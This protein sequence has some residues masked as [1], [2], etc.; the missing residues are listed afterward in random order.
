MG[1][2]IIVVIFLVL[3]LGLG[4][5]LF[6]SGIL[7]NAT[8]EFS[9]LL[10]ASSSTFFNAGS[11]YVPPV[12]ISQGSPTPSATTTIN[13]ADVPAGFTVSQLSPYFHKV[14]FGGVEPGSSGEIIL[15]G[16]MSPSSSIDITGWEIKSNR[17][18]EYVPQAIDLYDPSGLARAGDI[19]LQYG[20]YAYLYSASAPF[21]LRLNECIGYL[22]VEVKFTPQLP[23]N[24][25]QPNLSAIG[26]FTGACQNFIQSVGSC[27]TPELNNAPISNNDYACRDFI[28][29]NF[30]YTSCFNAHVS[31]SNFLSNQWWVWMGSSPLDQYHDNVYLYD[32]KGLLVDSYSY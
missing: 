18:G 26:T 15:S 20:Q 1:S 22:S 23:E 21:N 9:D 12:T 13:P 32:R 11:G 7:N 17:G 29:N 4:I 6:R 2:K 30:T 14:R 3:V 27:Q 10:H 25:P 19:T 8:G 31:D 16:Q 24:C 28:E 5:Y